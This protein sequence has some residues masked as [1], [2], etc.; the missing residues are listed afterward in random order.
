MCLNLYLLTQA[1]TSGQ[2]EVTPLETPMVGPC[3]S[4]SQE[5]EQQGTKSFASKTDFLEKRGKFLTELLLK[6]GNN[7]PVPAD[8][9]EDI[10]FDYKDILYYF[11][12]YQNCL[13]IMLS[14]TFYPDYHE[15]QQLFMCDICTKIFNVVL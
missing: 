7:F 4:T 13:S 1:T 8:T 12:I 3:T 9:Q 11:V 14:D 5:P 10:D 2:G 6:E 15:Q